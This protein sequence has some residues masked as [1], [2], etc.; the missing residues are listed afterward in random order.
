MHTSQRLTS[1]CRKASQ[2]FFRI[3]HSTTA[4]ARISFLFRPETV[5][6]PQ[7]TITTHRQGPKNEVGGVG[8]PVR[9]LK[10]TPKS[11]PE[12]TTACQKGTQNR[13]LENIVCDDARKPIQVTKNVQMRLRNAPN[14]QCSSLHRPTPNAPRKELSK[15]TEPRCGS[16]KNCK[17]T[18]V[19]QGFSYLACTKD[20]QPHE[21]I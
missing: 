19:L 10:R 12:T 1:D 17:N 15:G 16:S 4:E 8:P 20:Q 7:K 6:G 9:C 5:L 14:P 21:I 11:C 3:V 2:N 18:C 13:H